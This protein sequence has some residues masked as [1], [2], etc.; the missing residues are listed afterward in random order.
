MKAARFFVII[1][2]VLLSS[3]P[4][5][6]HCD[7]VDGPVV[8]D[9]NAALEKGD[10]TAVLKWVK[11]DDEREIRAA[12]EKTLAVRKAGG[13]ARQL[14]DTWFFETLV[15]VHRAGEGAPYSGLKPAGTDNGPAIRGGDEALEKGSIEDLEKLV[16][17]TVK[18]G[19]RERFTNLQ[20]LREHSTHNVEAGRAY[21][22]AY[23]DFL[24]YVERIYDDA[25]K[26]VARHEH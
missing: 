2:A 24:H 25:A 6:A 22:A 17:D 8:V 26:G 11:A 10:I 9:A 13:E 20:R 16:V 3:L 7:Q 15:R 21:T 14:A 1:F 23:A 12:F 19:M 18:K 4:L 5:L